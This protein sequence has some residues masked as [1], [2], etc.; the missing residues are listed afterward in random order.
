M[1][2]IEGRGSPTVRG[3]LLLAFTCVVWAT[4]AVGQETMI[5]EEDM[6][7]HAAD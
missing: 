3:R 4:L 5:G 1:S 2:T 6:I 7:G